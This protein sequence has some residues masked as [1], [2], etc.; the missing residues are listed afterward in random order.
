MAA[1]VEE[2]G[3]PPVPHEHDEGAALEHVADHGTLGGL[4]H[5]TETCC[6]GCRRLLEEQYLILHQLAE[7]LGSISD[8]DL[9]RLTKA[10]K[11]LRVLR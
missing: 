5:P 6:G 8:R 4:Y 2:A 9:V 11:A 10:A 1:Q 3:A 7:L